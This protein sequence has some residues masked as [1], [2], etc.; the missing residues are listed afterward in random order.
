MQ[1]IIETLLQSD[2]RVRVIGTAA[3][4]AE[5]IA[6][7]MSL[8]PDVITLD[9]EMPVMNGLEALQIIMERHPTP[10]I[11]LSGLTDAEIVLKSLNLGAVDFIAKP[12]GTVSIDLYKIREELLAKIKLATLTNI[13]SAIT[14]D[15]QTQPFPRSIEY[16]EIDFGSIYLLCG[17]W[18]IYRGP[19]RG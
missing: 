12:S 15:S 14:I 9:V 4:G 19:H 17:N 10:V 13:D 5:A 18:C 1:R 3:N 6:S 11:M 2:S 8:H 16:R 7:V